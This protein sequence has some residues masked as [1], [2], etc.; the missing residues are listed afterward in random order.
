MKLTVKANAKLNLTLD[1]VGKKDDG[2]HLLETVM[3]SV[4]LYD[5][6]T[7]RDDKSG[8]IT[9]STSDPN[10]PNDERNLAYKAAKA[11]FETTCIENPGVDIKIKKRI[12][13]EAGLA[14]GSADAAAVLTA[15]NEIFSADLSIEELCDIG[16]KLGADVAFCIVGGTVLARG[17]GNI[18]SPIPTLED[19][20]FVIAKPETSVSTAN[21][22]ALVDSY[23]GEFIRPDSIELGE[24]ICGGDIRAVAR[25]C[26]NVFEQALGLEE[27][28]KIKEIMLEEGALGACLTGSGSAVFAI[29]TD[30]DAAKDCAEKLERTYDDVFLAE[31]VSFGCEIEE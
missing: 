26:I 18:L 28:A 14:G 15:L 9:V 5:T 3:Q 11:F 8:G 1:V 20:F 29:F 2:Y 24:H 19:C 10:I 7:V 27:S 17:V 22:Y 23:Q 16:E 30:E 6:V 4:S 13:C 12:P 25:G 31:P 21:A